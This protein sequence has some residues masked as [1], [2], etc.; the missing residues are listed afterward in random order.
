MS[1]T[2]L[3]DVKL[4]SKIL[5]AFKVFEEKMPNKNSKTYFEVPAG[6]FWPYFCQF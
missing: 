2:T 6:L 1:V 4:Y 5:H 3:T